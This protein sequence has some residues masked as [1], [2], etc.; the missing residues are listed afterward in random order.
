MEFRIELIS[1]FLTFAGVYLSLRSIFISRIQIKLDEY[2][3]HYIDWENIPRRH[4]FIF[5][6]FGI[7]KDN[8]W[9]FRK[10]PPKPA[11]EKLL[12]SFFNFEEPFRAL[13]YI[14]LAI[15]LQLS[16]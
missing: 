9:L 10:A 7:N 11:D 6:F 1:S 15:I 16:Y 4:K 3:F 14:T 5:V 13:V 2:I 12:K 8:L